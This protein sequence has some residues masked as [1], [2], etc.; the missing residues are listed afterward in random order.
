MGKKEVQTTHTKTVD[1]CDRCGKEVMGGSLSRCDICRREV[2]YCCGRLRPAYEPG[3]P[4]YIDLGFHVCKDCDEAGADVTG[5]HFIDLIRAEV[6]RCDEAVDALITRWREWA[7][8]RR[9]AK[10]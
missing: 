9:E 6:K 10:S 8:G 4:V 1:V 3:C 5:S 7:K 2:G